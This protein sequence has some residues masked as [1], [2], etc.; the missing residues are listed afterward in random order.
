MQITQYFGQHA[1][2]AVG[3]YAQTKINEAIALRDQA[4][5]ETNEERKNALRAE[6]KGLEDNW[7]SKGVLRLAL[8]TVIGGLTGGADGALGA[9]TGTL[10][11][12][13][14]AQAL[15]DA[16]ISGPLAQTLTAIASTAVGAATGGTAGGAAAGNEV[17]NNFLKHDQAKAMKAEFDK[18]KANP[19]GCSDQDVR[20]ITQKYLALSQ[21]NIDAVNNC[22]RSGDAACVTRL[23]SQAATPGEIDTAIPMGYGAYAYAFIGRQNNVNNY[24]SVKGA[25][26]PFGTDAQQANE[27]R[28][29]RQANCQSVSAAA[30]DKLVDR[31]IDDRYTRAS[32]LMGL[33]FAASKIGSMT[34]SRLQMP[35]APAANIATAMEDLPP[36]FSRGSGGNGPVVGT[37]DPVT[38]RVVLSDP[39][40]P[41]PSVST[42]A[43]GG[44][45]VIGAGTGTVNLGILVGAG[46]NKTV[47]LVAGDPT[48]VVAMV[49]NGLIADLQTEAQQ[50]N[51]LAA[52]GLPVVRNYG[53]SYVN[54]QPGLVMDN[55]SGGMTVKPTF[56]DPALEARAFSSLNSNSIADLQKIQTYLQKNTIGD[57]QVM[58]TPQ[59]RVLL[60]DPSG[61]TA[62]PTSNIQ[63]LQLLQDMLDIA[64]GRK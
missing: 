42:P 60:N 2:K 5:N 34:A 58:V 3:D 30:C 53:I 26:S 54:G 32:I 44:T 16:G 22:I 56:N 6:A 9:A 47:Y 45:P 10:T 39:R 18:C 13:M 43:S 35:K 17:V 49:N 1:S 64:K 61:L 59:G 38:G 37:V 23:E 4:E 46:A 28:D 11:A 52:A 15:A 12:P 19:Q 31:A 14:V 57:F 48:K 20:N 41:A 24:G 27:V 36:G 55:I 50:L 63:T 62:Q 21:S 51:Q 7:G 29:F 8:H 33:G 25:D 40:L